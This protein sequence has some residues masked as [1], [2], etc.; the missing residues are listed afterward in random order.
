CVFYWLRSGPGRCPGR[1][2][3]TGLQAEGG[4]ELQQREGEARAQVDE[5]VAAEVGAVHPEAVPQPRDDEREEAP[6]VPRGQARGEGLPPSGGMGGESLIG[7]M[8]LGARND[9][10][11]LPESR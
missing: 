6:Q 10:E 7:E 5:E 11:Q 2:V 9:A 4:H 8:E 3:E 1:R